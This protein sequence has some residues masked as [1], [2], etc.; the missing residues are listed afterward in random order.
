[1]NDNDV[2]HAMRVFQQDEQLMVE[3]ASSVGLAAMLGGKLDDLKG[4]KVALVI[5]SR[6]ID[7]DRYNQI[8]CQ[9]YGG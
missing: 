4:R 6:N 8:I 5:S 9:H 3:G 1:M 7:A 2:I